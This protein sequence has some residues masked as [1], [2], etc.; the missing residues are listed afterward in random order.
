MNTT[1]VAA[2]AASTTLTTPPVQLSAGLVHA[3]ARKKIARITI[4]TLAIADE[5]RMM[6]FRSSDRIG[7][8]WV[9][10]DNASTGTLADL[11]LY[12]AGAAHDGAVKDQDLFGAVLAIDNGMARTDVF[13][14]ATTLADEMRWKQLWELTGM[15]YA[16]DPIVDFDLV[17]T[18]KTTALSVAA[19]EVVVEVDYTSG[20]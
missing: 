17:F 9:M 11:G 12:L 20:D 19:T 10:C 16:V 8:I 15:G 18:C 13:T 6:T 4:G 7:A 1:G 5:A 2:L 3:R 14:Q